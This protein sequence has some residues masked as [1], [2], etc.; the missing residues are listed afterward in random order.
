MQLHAGNTTFSCLTY[1]CDSI[2]AVAEASKPDLIASI[3]DILFGIQFLIMQVKRI[4]SGCAT[5]KFLHPE[6]SNFEFVRNIAWK[7]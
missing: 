6:T 1:G 7:F 3:L 2:R 5:T 4:F